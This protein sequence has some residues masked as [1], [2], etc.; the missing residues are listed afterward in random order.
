MKKR[1]RMNRRN[2]SRAQFR[3]IQR[4][5]KESCLQDY[6]EW[7]DSCVGEMEKAN[8]FGDVMKI[9]HMVNKLSQKP[10]PPPATITKDEQGNPIQS[11]QTVVGVWERFLKGKFQAAEPEASRRLLEPLPKSR[12]EEDELKRSE[13]EEA[14]KRL[15]NVKATG[16]DDISIEVYKKCPKLK[17]ELFHCFNSSS[18]FGTKKRYP[19]TLGSRNSSCCINIKGRRTT[20]R[21]TDVSVFLIM[22]TK[23]WLILS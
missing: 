4:R 19:S 20:P 8:D 17:D 11:P 14:L 16:P 15:K 3:R 9:Y 1:A 18:M 10:K 6:V 23:S 21:S 2:S 7:V 12:S 13:F 22:T 5:I